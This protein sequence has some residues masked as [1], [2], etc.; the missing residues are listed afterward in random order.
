[1]PALL[2]DDMLDHTKMETQMRFG[3]WTKTTDVA[4]FISKLTGVARCINA[5]YCVHF[6]SQAVVSGEAAD[7]LSAI[8]SGIISG[9]RAGQSGFDQS[10]GFVY[11]DKNFIAILQ[12]KWRKINGQAM[13]VGHGK[14]DVC[15]E[16]ALLQHSLAHG[17]QR[18]LHAMT[19][20]GRKCFKKNPPH[21]L[22]CFPE[23]FRRVQVRPFSFHRGP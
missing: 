22:P 1:M 5:R 19:V 13:P 14:A 17:I 12:V 7:R 4:R 9:A 23:I 15:D 2:G 21:G 11:R 3:D 10:A 16:I 8:Q 18:V 20:M 6:S